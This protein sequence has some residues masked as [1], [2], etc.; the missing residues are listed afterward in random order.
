MNE[1]CHCSSYTHS[2][3][4]WWDRSRCCDICWSW[5][6]W[7]TPPLLC[8]EWIPALPGLAGSSA[9]S[10]ARS[11]PFVRCRRSNSG[12]HMGP[13]TADTFRCLGQESLA[14]SLGDDGSHSQQPFKSYGTCLFCRLINCHQLW[15]DGAERTRRRDGVLW[16]IYSGFTCGVL[17]DVRFL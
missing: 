2:D 4:P 10:L 9:G 8:C 5:G 1:W 11:S 17:A 6:S 13:R 7:W 12:G 14:A 3:C 15:K 16:S